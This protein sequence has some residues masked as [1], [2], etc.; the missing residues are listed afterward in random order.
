MVGD[1]ILSFIYSDTHKRNSRI[2][3]DVFAGEPDELSA[4]LRCHLLV[5]KNL[6]EFCSASVSSPKCLEGSKFQFYQIVN[7]ARALLLEPEDP[8]MSWVWGGIA[9]LNGMRNDY[10]HQL[11]PD[12][13]AITSKKKKFINLLRPVIKDEP[14]YQG[15]DIPFR[16]YL[17]IL[18][19]ALSAYLHF[20]LGANK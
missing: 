18:A 5:E 13:K 1:S 8:K 15:V 10:A 9:I 6:R 20:C 17:G 14:V 19:G 16:V 3:E 2:L 11:E 4:L 7:L 12:P